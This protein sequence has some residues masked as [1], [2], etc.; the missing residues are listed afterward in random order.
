MGTGGFVDFGQKIQGFGYPNLSILRPSDVPMFRSPDVPI[1]SSLP[2]QCH[3]CLSV[4]RF[5]RFCK[6]RN[7]LLSSITSSGQ[8]GQL[9]IQHTIK[10]HPAMGCI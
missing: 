1:S 9:L 3:H 8:S 6:S 5:L 2:D 7:T 4:V 10:S